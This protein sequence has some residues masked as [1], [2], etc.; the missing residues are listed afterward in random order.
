MQILPTLAESISRQNAIIKYYHA[1]KSYSILFLIAFALFFCT[2]HGQNNLPTRS[3]DGTTY[4]QVGDNWSLFD[5]AQQQ[6]IALNKSVVSILFEEGTAQTT[7]SALQ[8]KYDLHLD[9]MASTGW[10]DFSFPPSNDLFAKCDSIL[11]EGIVNKVEVTSPLVYHLWP[12]DSVFQDPTTGT[13]LQWDLIKTKV[14]LAWDYNTGDTNTLV[15]YIDTGADWWEQEFIQATGASTGAFWHNPGED[16]WTDPNDPTTGNGIDDDGNGFIDDW[17]GWNFG[18]DTN[19]V[20]DGWQN[21]HGTASVGRVSAKTNNLIGIAGVAGGWTNQLG[22]RAM[23]V[24]TGEQATGVP[25]SYSSVLDDAILYAAEHGANII[26]ITS[27][28]YG[29]FASISS[30]IESA[31]NEYG[32]IIVA[33][34]GNVVGLHDSAVFPSSHPLVLAITSTTN[35]DRAKDCYIGAHIDLGAPGINVPIINAGSRA[36]PYSHYPNGSGTSLAAP[37]VAGVFALMAAENNCLSNREAYNIIRYR[38]DTVH[39][40][41]GSSNY[42]YHWNLTKPWHS[43]ALGYGRVNA[44]KAVQTAHNMQSDSIDLY[45]KDRYDDF[46]YANSYPAMGRFDL[47]PDIWARNQPDGRIN[48][49]DEQLEYDSL[50]PAWIYVRVTNKSCVPSFGNESLTLRWSKASGD[51]SWPQNW[52]GSNPNIGNIITNIPLGVIAPGADTI[53]EIAW[54]IIPNLGQNYWAT[55]LLAEVVSPQEPNNTAFTNLGQEIR[56]N[57]NF[58]IKNLRIE[59]FYPGKTLP[60]L[61][62]EYYPHGRFLFVRNRKLQTAPINLQFNVPDVLSGAS[63][64]EVAEVQIILTQNLW[65]KYQSLA[66]EDVYGLEVL[67][68]RKLVV[69]ANH[70]YINN[71]LFLADEADSIYIGFSFLTDEIGDKK[72]FLF[73]IDQFE[74]EATLLGSVSFF[75]KRSERDDFQAEAGL[76]QTIDQGQTVL[77]HADDIN[78]AAIYNWY[79]SSDSLI[80]S[81]LS[82]SLVP[83]ITQYYTLEVIAATD[84]YK[85]FDSVQVVVNPYAIKSIAPNPVLNTTTI[86]YDAEEAN[87]AYFMI[88]PLAGN[89]VFNNYILN[90][91][92]TTITMHLSSYT[93]GL[94]L[95]ILV[96]D[97]TIV[98][99][100]LFTKQ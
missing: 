82:P 54:N 48:R 60:F 70:A 11:S 72:E 74:D 22:A 91:Q 78:E 100:E 73:H 43:K 68:E 38:A 65:D 47:G 15:G 84:G 80:Y 98:D 17:L 7:I 44:L 94:Y 86:T 3:F 25:N 71:L 79:D 41:P 14:H 6:F 57:N 63:I 36:A 24:K 19:D 50:S 40:T 93:S 8:E 87:T 18:W 64:V 10:C 52:D 12:N 67:D 39:S 32:C 5:P 20:R 89:N 45:I 51:F 42:D 99:S 26:C 95:V 66:P 62:G 9:R 35:A 75:I 4:Y 28:A 92:D 1:M 23:I 56:A 33:S 13:V 96:C 59:N 53:V 21:P 77:L 83:E 34:A 55:C 85:D 69:R 76:N 49:F 46:G 30:A 97:G 16:A 90:P 2:V 58:A 88:Y 81:G 61:N 27:G 37:L 29:N 31:Y